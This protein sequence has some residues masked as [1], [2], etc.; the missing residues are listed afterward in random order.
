[1]VV[2]EDGAWSGFLT[3]GCAEPAIAALAQQSLAEGRN[4]LARL[5]HESPYVDIQLPCGS[6]IDL[7]FA[8]DPPEEVLVDAL[9]CLR[10]RRAVAL[11]FALAE[12]TRV[13][14]IEQGAAPITAQDSFRRWFTPQRRLLVLGSGPVSVALAVLA[15]G[16]HHDVI[17]LTPDS[18]TRAA[19]LDRDIDVHAL[20]SAAD[21]ARVELDADSSACLLFHDHERETEL[22]ANLL[23]LPLYYIAAL[24]SQQT[25]AT[26]LEALRSSGIQPQQLQ[27]IHGP[28][29]IDIRARTPGEIALSILAEATLRYR[30]QVRTALERI[31]GP[32]GELAQ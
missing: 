29:G 17:V 22:L 13:R 10:E 3:G 30:K 6:G 27:R 28:A 19:L 9:G 26:R 20:N 23:E 18:A 5:G 32:L 14:I 7:F 1:M 4:Q 12:Q 31:G 16:Q 8:I 15:A 25:H 21:L 24:G 11:E 2:A